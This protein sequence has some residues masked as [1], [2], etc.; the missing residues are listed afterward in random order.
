M[1]FIMDRQTFADL[2]I[3]EGKKS[4]SRFFDRPITY[5]GRKELL[6][7]FNYPLSDIK[8]IRERQK[9]ISYIYKKKLISLL[10]IE[11]ERI[12]KSLIPFLQHQQAI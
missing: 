11:N 9:S 4:I 6:D 7:M 8:K 3:F 1:A 2:E 5:G 12:L 10:I